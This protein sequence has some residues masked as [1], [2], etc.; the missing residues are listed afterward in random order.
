MIDADA[1][2]RVLVDGVPADQVPVN[3]RGLAYGDG[4]FETMLFIDGR[5]WLWDRHMTRLRDGCARLGL[6]APA[7]DRL[8]ADSLSTSSDLARAIVRITLT[9]GSSTRGYATDPVL[10]TRRILAAE[11]APAAA[12]DWYDRG[13]R[14]RLCDIRLASQ[15][16][17]AGIKHLNRLEQVLARAEWCDP[18]I[19][20]GLMRDSDDNVICATAA[21]LF[22]VIDGRLVTPALDHCGVAGVMRAQVLA[23]HAVQ[24]RAIGCAEMN[25]ADEMFLS[26]AVRG[27][28]PVAA[29]GERQ[30]APGPFTRA[31]MGA[32]NTALLGK[33]ERA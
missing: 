5:C 12:R 11:P 3:D 24:V 29:L 8:R 20:E 33:A 22:A 23:G 17:L 31:L 18:A 9:R 13:L 15:P 4:L 7:E 32:Y 10:P 16:R 30:W 19:D 26:N 25:G 2:A 27:I 28:R 1:R 6:H 14:L 21:N